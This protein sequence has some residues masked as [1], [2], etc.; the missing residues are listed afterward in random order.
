MKKVLFPILAL[1]LTLSMATSVAVAGGR[2]VNAQRVPL[3][4]VDLSSSDFVRTDLPSQG[5][6]VL[7]DPM[8]NVTFIIQG[9]VENLKSNH[10]Y[11]MWIRQFDTGQY[12]G[13]FIMQYEPLDYYQLLTFTTNDEGR[14][15]FHLNIRSDELA[16]GT[17]EIQI[18]IN[19]PPAPEAIGPTVLAT[20][21]YVEVTVK[22]DEV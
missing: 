3:Y 10:L 7:V 1:V 11:T 12:T 13:T 22:T 6:V 17:Y 15:R 5:E 16:P 20:V 9:N 19:D 21:K 18:A 14:G 4:P 8:G 2:R